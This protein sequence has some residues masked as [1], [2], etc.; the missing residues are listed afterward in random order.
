MATSMKVY[1]I[2]KHRVPVDAV[3]IDRMT[4]WGN[5]FTIKAHT[6]TRQ[7]AVDRYAAWLL[8]RPEMVTRARRELCGKPLACWCAPLLCHGRVLLWAANAPAN[9]L[10]TYAGW[11]AHAA[12]HKLG[13]HA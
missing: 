9:D 8:A 2:A 4:V 11:V 5:P 1:N 6:R 3:R 12:S 13:K 10:L 7:Q